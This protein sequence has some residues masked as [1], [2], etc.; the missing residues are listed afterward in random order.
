MKSSS[1]KIASTFLLSGL[2]VLNITANPP[3]ITTENESSLLKKARTFGRSLYTTGSTTIGNSWTTLRSLRNFRNATDLAKHIKQLGTNG[4]THPQTIFTLYLTVTSGAGLF[5][6]KNFYTTA[7]VSKSTIF[8]IIANATI[9]AFNS[10]IA[11]D[12]RQIQKMCPTTFANRS[13]YQKTFAHNPKIIT[14]LFTAAGFGSRLIGIHSSVSH[15]L[16]Y[17]NINMLYNMAKEIREIKNSCK[18]EEPQTPQQTRTS[19]TSS[20]MPPILPNTTE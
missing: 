10:S 8:H 12:Q 20:T 17:K 11:Y 14:T 2:L 16:E 9:V 3:L 7:F 19:S 4:I 13:L 15:L 6:L 5:L 18:A 1:K